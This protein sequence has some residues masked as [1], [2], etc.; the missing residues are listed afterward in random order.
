M[1]T[2]L[3]I[4]TPGD[5]YEVEA[6]R[7]AEQVMRMPAPH[8][9]SEIH[10]SPLHLQRACAGCNSGTAKTPENFS[11]ARALSGGGHPLSA[12]A[13]SYFEPRFGYDFS[14]V[15]IHTDNAAMESA[16]QVKALAY[17]I[18]HDVVLGAG[19]TA[20]ETPAGRRLLAHELTHVIQ[21]GGGQ[22]RAGSAL[23]RSVEPRVSR[24][25]QRVQTDAG[26]E[27]ATGVGPAITAGT[28]V[29]NNTIMGHTFTATNC[30]GLYGCNVNF[31][32]SK[33]YSGVYTLVGPGR[34][35]RGIYVKI[36]VSFNSP[37]CGTCATLHAIQNVRNIR[38]GTGGATEVADPVDPGRRAKSGWGDPSA[39]SR[40]W[41]VDTTDTNPIFTT[42]W[43]ANPGTNT[44]P[45]EL[46]DV[47]GDWTDARN[48][49]KDFQSCA[50]CDNAGTQR[51][52]IACVNWGL[53]IDSTGVV[54]FSP[55]TPVASCGPTQ[56]LEDATTRFEGIAG[57]QSANI[58]FTRETGED[59]T[60]QRSALWFQFNST[61][62][63]EDA[64]VHSSIIMEGALRRIRQHLVALGANARIV[65]HGY[66]SEEGDAGYNMGLS[67]RRAEAIQA[68]LI[69]A[70]IPAA[71]ITIQPHGED[72]SL[73]TRACNRR[74]EIEHTA[75]APAGAGP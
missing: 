32:F 70:G 20:T 41:R 62:L 68:Q 53:Y 66:A 59:Q 33:A 56:Q 47:P 16:R 43:D 10:S 40:G 38:H 27:A 23:A 44:T 58:D 54:S 35:V 75:V 51:R 39:P 1:Q 57:N 22:R 63:R 49:G 29:P 26:Y 73:P 64:E 55:A 4:S 17:T 21:Q 13:R 8:D 37:I 52:V 11:E 2:K 9:T 18:G 12:S 48:T 34:D 7:V 3:A 71:R 42:S 72:R 69:A 74:V 46:W 67:R 28:M 14:Q 30:R 24:M 6:D 60:S 36:S 19:Q 61:T 50:I 45:A 31:A 15:R 5:Q 25:I 65:V